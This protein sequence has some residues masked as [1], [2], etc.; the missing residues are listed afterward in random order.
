M[1]LSGP[2][3]TELCCFHAKALPIPVFGETVTVRQNRRKNKFEV[4]AYVSSEVQSNSRVQYN[5]AIL[6]CLNTFAPSRPTCSR[7]YR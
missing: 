3:E 6:T 7:Y 1:H 4:V 5:I 2:C